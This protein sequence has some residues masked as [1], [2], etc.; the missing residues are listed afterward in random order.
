MK[1]DKRILS[2]LQKYWD[3]SF[4]ASN[5]CLLLSGSMLGLMSE[6]VLSY[7]SP[8]YGRRSRDILLDGLYFENARE[9][10]NMSFQDALL[11]YM[12]IG[13]VPEYLIRASEYNSF[14]PEFER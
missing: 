1:S 9:F 5:V 14:K 3:T 4:A 11:L 10:L 7:A 13:G 12:S 6:M 2:V 8:L